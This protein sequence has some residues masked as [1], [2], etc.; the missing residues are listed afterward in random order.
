MFLMW[1]ILNEAGRGIRVVDIATARL[2]PRPRVH[3]LFLLLEKLKGTTESLRFMH[4]LIYG[5][6]RGTGL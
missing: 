5:L 2:Q 6:R 4:L 1:L 3:L